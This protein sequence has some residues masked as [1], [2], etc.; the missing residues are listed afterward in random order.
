[1]SRTSWNSF[2]HQPA[3]A[4]LAT[5]G[6]VVSILAILFYLSH[7]VVGVLEAL[8][9]AVAEGLLSLL[10]LAAVVMQLF[11]GVTTAFQ[12]LYLSLNLPILF[13]APVSVRAVFAVKSLVIGLAN[14]LPVTVFIGIT[15]TTV[16]YLTG[17]VVSLGLWLPG[18][19]LSE[20]LNLAAMRLIPPH[21]AREATGAIGAA[22]GLVIALFFQL[23][24]WL[25]DGQ[26]F[27]QILLR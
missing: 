23:P 15:A 27:Q 3:G 8:P 13:A 21:R 17:I 25:G 10:F 24:N 12:N 14:L 7:L 5:A 22:A 2:R 18:T 6:F 19:T 1:M 16:Y 20:L 26:T 11:T 4:K 9:P